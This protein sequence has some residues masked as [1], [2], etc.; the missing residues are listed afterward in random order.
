MHSPKDR[1][2]YRVAKLWDSAANIAISVMSSFAV[3]VIILG[4]ANEA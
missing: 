4:L 2:D 3:A 1:K